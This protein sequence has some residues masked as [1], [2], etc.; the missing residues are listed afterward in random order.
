MNFIV[1]GLPRTGTTILYNLCNAIL[2][3]SGTVPIASHAPEYDFDQSNSLDTS[4]LRLTKTHRIKNLP[5]NATRPFTLICSVRDPLSTI[6]SRRRTIHKADTSKPLRPDEI[7]EQVRSSLAYHRTFFSLAPSAHDVFC[8]SAEQLENLDSSLVAHLSASLGVTLPDGSTEVLSQNFTLQAVQRVIDRLSQSQGWEPDFRSH[9]ETTQWHFD[10]LRAE[11]YPYH[12]KRRLP[13]SERMKLELSQALLDDIQSFPQRKSVR[14]SIKLPSNQIE[15]PN[16]SRTRRPTAK[17]KRVVLLS[18]PLDD[19][20]SIDLKAA[21]QLQ[22]ETLVQ[23]SAN[24][25]IDLTF[26]SSNV[27]QNLYTGSG[28]SNAQQLDPGAPPLP[29]LHSLFNDLP[30]DGVI[31]YVNA[32]I[33]FSPDF[34]EVMKR[35]LRRGVSAFSTTRLDLPE[36][37]PPYSLSRSALNQGTDHPGDDCFVMTASTASKILLGPTIIGVPPIGKVLALGCALND[38][39]YTKYWYDRQT[40]HIG[41]DSPWKSDSSRSFL[42]EINQEIFEIIVG[43]Y[44]RIFSEDKV[45]LALRNI[46]RQRD[47]KSNW[48]SRAEPT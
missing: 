17:K 8:V 46:F 34:F 9:D 37:N 45:E 13:K 22:L 10:H 31:I 38:P 12:D 24:S 41:C 3:E 4:G 42:R 27:Y 40:F 29:F 32:D 15:T 21:N 7:R 14:R 19:D 25:S 20:A 28:L 44:K 5:G 1:Y 23:A 6:L 16:G 18:P 39:T 47:G 33:A 26:A 35:R 30:P 43:E 36:Q 48:V 2:A 11:R